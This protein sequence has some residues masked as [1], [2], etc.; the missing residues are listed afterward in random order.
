MKSFVNLIQS[1]H[2]DESGA[3]F[4]EYTALLGVILAAAIGVLVAV[5]NWAGGLWEA[6]CDTLDAEA[7]AGVGCTVGGAAA[8]AP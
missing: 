4:I 3:S 5:G 8:P 7:I 6:L 1:L 2:A